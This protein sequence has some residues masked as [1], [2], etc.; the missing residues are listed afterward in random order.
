MRIPFGLRF[1]VCCGVLAAAC[2]DGSDVPDGGGS[3]DGGDGGDRDGSSDASSSEPV[4]NGEGLA[5]WISGSVR[6][7]RDCLYGVQVADDPG[8]YDL[9]RR[10]HGPGS[11]CL[12]PYAL[13]VVAQANYEPVVSGAGG[14]ILQLHS[15]EVRLATADGQTIAFNATGFQLPNPFLVSTMGSLFLP[16]DGST[17]F[18]LAVVETIPLEYGQQLTPFADQQIIA[19]IKLLGTTNNGVELVFEPFAQ[20][21]DLCRFCLT[22]C[23]SQLPEMGYTLDQ[24]LAGQC[25]DHAGADGR[26]CV[27]PGC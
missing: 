16:T 27:D 26:V 23:M 5:G 8:T 21:I 25:P 17:A 2:S 14:A 1:A 4:R 20:R 19:E 18:A 24:L 3:P 12:R 13:Q 7:D 11:S 9:E 6:P 22:V 10:N 15:A